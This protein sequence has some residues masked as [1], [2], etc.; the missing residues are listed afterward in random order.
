[1]LLRN[2]EWALQLLDDVFDAPYASFSSHPWWEQ[3]AMFL[4]L[5]RARVASATSSFSDLLADVVSK[6]PLSVAVLPQQLM[7]AYP[8]ELAGLLVGSR[9]AAL[10]ATFHR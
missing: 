5:H 7:N 6:P 9:G 10:H 2:T 1:M 8:K 3:A 4:Y